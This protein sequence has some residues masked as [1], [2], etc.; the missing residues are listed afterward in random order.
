MSR[1]ARNADAS[2][3]LNLS[4][5]ARRRANI[6]RSLVARAIRLGTSTNMKHGIYS[7]VAVRPEVLDEVAVLYARA[8][9]L[10][11]VRDGNLVEATARLIVRLRKLDMALAD[12]PANVTFGTMYGRSEM[13]LVRN[14][15][16][17]GLTPTAAARLGL[18]H[19][20]ARERARRMGETVLDGYRK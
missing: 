16:A 20:D 10:D 8:E 1:A 15:D 18:Q 5:D 4:S 9:W 3:A 2:M 6:R 11:P 17:L 14:L 12:D 7:E 19:L 13:Q